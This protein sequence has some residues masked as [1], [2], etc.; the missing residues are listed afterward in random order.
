[1]NGYL[2]ETRKRASTI[3]A[4]LMA[5]PPPPPRGSAARAQLAIVRALCDESE[6]S[7]LRHRAGVLESQIADEVA[8]LE[9]CGPFGVP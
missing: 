5:A 2:A 6:W 4:A 8:R 1:M 9:A 3:D 7:A